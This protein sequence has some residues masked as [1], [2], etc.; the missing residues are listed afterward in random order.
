MD[1]LPA[2]ATIAPGANTTST[3]RDLYFELSA[4]T[5]G[6]EQRA[7]A[8]RFLDGQL[9]AGTTSESSLPADPHDLLAWMRSGTDEVGESYGAYLR[10]R[11]GGEP[12]RYFPAKAHALAFLQ[13]VAPTKLVDGAWL[14]GTLERWDDA[15]FRPLITTYLEELGAGVREKN[16]VALYQRLL[17]EI[18]CDNWRSLPDRNFV[19]G[20]IQLAL[21]WNAEHFLPELIGFNLGYEQLLLHLL[22]TSYE[23][24]ELGIDPYYFVLHVTV[25]NASTGHAVKAVEALQGLMP[26]VG[27][28]TGFYRRVQNGFRLNGLGAGTNELIA[29]FDLEHELTRILVLKSGVGK[30]MHSDYCRF[31]GR[32]VNQWLALPA[33][34]PAFLSELVKAGWIQRGAPAEQSRFWR[35]IHGDNA[36]MFGVFN[37]YEQEILR[38][39]IEHPRQRQGAAEQ[40]CGLTHRAA[41]RR[42]DAA[43]SA[44]AQP[45]KDPLRPLLR[46]HADRRDSA[47]GFS[48]DLRLLEQQLAAMASKQQVMRHLSTLMSPATHHTPAGLMATRIFQRLLD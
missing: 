8:R 10:G 11:R 33:Q 19:Q 28:S 16:H 46:G 17:A 30:N 29:S 24:N 12:R 36:E 43:F 45:D 9:M 41:R 35:L 2:L 25:D 42:R 13:A 44:T 14:F 7:R 31:A 20:A 22:I 15:A 21:A 47:A 37:A 40:P 6:H 39:W 34:V 38:C 48:T 23:L 32:T 27:D 4:G 5:P 3:A 18:G 1:D 26:R